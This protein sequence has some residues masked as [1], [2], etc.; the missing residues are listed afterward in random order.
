M[1]YVVVIKILIGT[2]LDKLHKVIYGTV[3][4]SRPLPSYEVERYQLVLAE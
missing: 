3:E 4:Y 1:H 2:Y